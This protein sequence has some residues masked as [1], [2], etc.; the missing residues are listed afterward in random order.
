M[1][2]HLNG[3]LTATDSLPIRGETTDLHKL[4]NHCSGSIC[5]LMLSPA[6][7]SQGWNLLPLDF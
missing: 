3:L 7:P 5:V 1:V 2:C 4:H 6:G